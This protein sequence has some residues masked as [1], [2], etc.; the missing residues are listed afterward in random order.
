M[1]KLVLV[2]TTALVAAGIGSTTSF[3]WKVQRSFNDV[4]NVLANVRADIPQTKALSPLVGNFSLAGSIPA[5]TLAP[6][7]PEMK[8]SGTHSC[9][10]IMNNLFIE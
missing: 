2:V 9:K 7:Q 1:R 5:R 6:D 10:W 8:S 3:A 4:V